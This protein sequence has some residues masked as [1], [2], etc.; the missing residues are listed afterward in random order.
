MQDYLKDVY[1]W[2]ILIIFLIAGCDSIHDFCVSRVPVACVIVFKLLNTVL[3]TAITA[4]KA[5]VNDQQIITATYLTAA[6]TQ[7]EPGGDYSAWLSK[8]SNGGITAASQVEDQTVTYF[9]TRYPIQLNC[10]TRLVISYRDIINAIAANPGVDINSDILNANNTLNPGGI[11][12]VM[13]IDLSGDEDWDINFSPTEKKYIGIFI[14]NFF[15]P[16]PEAQPATNSSTPCYISFDAGSNMPDKIFG[17]MDQVMNL[18]TPLNIADSATTNVHLN[19]QRNYYYFPDEETGFVFSSNIFTKFLNLSLRVIKT[20]AQQYGHNTRYD[21]SLDAALLGLVVGSTTFDKNHTSGPGVKYLSEIITNIRQNPPTVPVPANKILDIWG[22]ITDVITAFVRAVVN[23]SNISSFFNDALLF[24]IKRGGDWEQ[25]NATKH[26]NDDAPLGSPTRGRSILCTI[27][28]LCALYSRMIK[29]HTIYHYT[30]KL[31]L[32]R[33]VTEVDPIASARSTLIFYQ[34]KT[35][36]FL[37]VTGGSAI[38]NSITDVLTT[39]ITAGETAFFPSLS[40]RNEQDV[41]ITIFAK[42][43]LLKLNDDLRDI[44]SMTVLDPQPELLALLNYSPPETDSIENILEIITQLTSQLSVIESQGPVYLKLSNLFGKTVTVSNFQPQIDTL[45]KPITSG[46]KFIRGELANYNYNVLLSLQKGIEEINRYNPDSRKSNLV[47]YP[48]V[49]DK[50]GF[51][52]SIKLFF[53]S[54]G[55]PEPSSLLDEAHQLLVNISIDQLGN[56]PNIIGNIISNTAFDTIQKTCLLLLSI[57][58]CHY[59]IQQNGQYLEQNT[60]Y[61]SLCKAVFATILQLH[62]PL[63]PPPGNSGGGKKYVGGTKVGENLTDNMSLAFT[64]L[65]RKITDVSESTLISLGAAIT[66]NSIDRLFA[67]FLSQSDVYFGEYSDPIIISR[68]YPI[69]GTALYY[70]QF[71]TSAPIICKLISITEQGVYT[72]VDNVGNTR[73]VALY[74]TVII[75]SEGNVVSYYSPSLDANFECKLLKGGVYLSTITP[76]QLEN[77]INERTIGAYFCDY[78]DEVTKHLLEYSDYQQMANY[79]YIYML[80]AAS[81]SEFGLDDWTKLTNWYTGIPDIGG[82][83][84]S[85]L[86][87]KI[88]GS[89]KL[90]KESNDLYYRLIVN[91]PGPGIDES[92]LR[93]VR[94]EILNNFFFIIYWCFYLRINGV[95]KNYIPILV[96]TTFNSFFIYNLKINSTTGIDLSNYLGYYDGI[97]NNFYGQYAVSALLNGF[98]LPELESV[99]VGVP[100]H[101]NY[102]VS[103]NFFNLLN[104][105]LILMKFI[106]EDP[107]NGIINFTTGF[108]GEFSRL[109]INREFRVGGKLKSKRNRKT[110]KAGRKNQSKSL[111]KRIRRNKVTKRNTPNKKNNRRHD[112]SNKKANRK[113]RK[114]SISRKDIEKTD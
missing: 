45:T 71:P 57:V 25:C 109:S 96:F 53:E 47:H 76:E 60:L 97:I 74:D 63:P 37:N 51:F 14:L 46:G 99:L 75:L 54:I 34:Q 2:D 11:Y 58:N 70:R 92:N 48:T 9:E 4:A 27:D 38:K 56:I 8:N 90:S 82:D 66:G 61:I 93:R 49:L 3:R 62:A 24:D 80:F 78:E 107:T 17:N 95:K 19:G 30:T 81:N 113:T 72:I 23:A 91:P 40:N 85:L 112:K 32:Y 94:H 1:N 55:V 68:I 16:P 87:T 21:F 29:Q 101:K 42:L 102:V 83:E 5:A 105:L 84:Y 44:T 88:L 79:F 111:L 18:V 7:R 98:Q 50:L 12:N 114:K 89:Y 59:P 73:E 100:S 65:S 22:F 108:L 31:I 13:E 36:A 52:K 77:E 26:A 106:K 104:R 110:R 41:T 67:G 43:Q 10:T 39:N 103:S 69:P 6:G 86:I 28:R 35:A 20:G 64:T 15:F 33:F